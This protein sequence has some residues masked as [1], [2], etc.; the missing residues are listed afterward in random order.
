MIKYGLS[1]PRAR[2]F[3]NDRLE[4]MTLV[5]FRTFAIIWTVILA[6]AVRASWGAAAPLTAA[7]LIAVGIAAWVLF[8]YAMHRFFFHLKLRSAIGRHLIFMAHGNHHAV[9]GD[10]LRNIMPP[11]ISVGLAI[12]IWL[13]LSAAFGAAG[14]LLFLGFALGYVAYD[15]VHYACHQ[16]PV[17][18]R[19]MS[20]L[21][22]H[23]I[24]HHC[25]EKEGNYAITAIFL[26]R[27][28]GTNVAGKR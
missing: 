18:G 23:H 8:E 13:T 20:R 21:R 3:R 4:R 28:F 9:P 25:S 6:L 17:R 5:S 10:P 1:S 19:L 16:L 26:D 24:R 14:S 27:V 12:P 15:T 22:R 7:G 11:M 2:L